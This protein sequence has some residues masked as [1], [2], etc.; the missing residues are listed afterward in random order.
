MAYSSKHK[1]G[2]T[3]ESPTSLSSFFENGKWW[4]QYPV[5][6][7]VLLHLDCCN[8]FSHYRAIVVEK[9]KSEDRR[10]ARFGDLPVCYFSDA[11]QQINFNGDFLPTEAHDNAWHGSWRPLTNL[12]QTFWACHLC[13]FNV[14]SIFFQGHPYI[15]RTT[16]RHEKRSRCY[17]NTKPHQLFWGDQEMGITIC[18]TSSKPPFLHAAAFHGPSSTVFC[19]GNDKTAA[20]LCQLQVATT[21]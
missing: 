3:W 8:S 9:R 13:T 17:A 2:I 4:V 7:A 11:F 5:T 12:T 19:A 15:W 14:T 10:F 18:R 6:Y 1:H 21:L 20:V 16:V